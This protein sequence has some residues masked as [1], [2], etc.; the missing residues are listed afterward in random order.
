MKTWIGG[1][2]RPVDDLSRSDWMQ[3]WC[4]E[5]REAAV[6]AHVAWMLAEY[7]QTDPGIKLS[8]SNALDV[9]H[10]PYLLGLDVM[11]TADFAFAKVLESVKAEITEPMARVAVFDPRAANPQAELRS[12]IQRG[13]LVES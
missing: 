3:F 7:H 10:A 11:V 5:I 9:L 2:L 4:T 6:Q 1:Y 13:G 12:A 8:T